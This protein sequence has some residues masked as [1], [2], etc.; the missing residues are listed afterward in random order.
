MNASEILIAL[1]DIKQFFGMISKRATLQKLTAN[2]FAENGTAQSRTES[3]VLLTKFVQI[4]KEK[5]QNAQN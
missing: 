5:Q 2:A 3:L 1:M 4:Y